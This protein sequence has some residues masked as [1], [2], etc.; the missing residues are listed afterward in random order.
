MSLKDF[1]ELC[2]LGLI[3]QEFNRAHQSWQ[4]HQMAC[5]AGGA[6]TRALGGKKSSAGASQ[7]RRRSSRQV[8]QGAKP[9]SLP[10][11]MRALADQRRGSDLRSASSAGSSLMAAAQD[12]G[13]DDE[14]MDTIYANWG[15]VEAHQDTGATTSATDIFLSTLKKVHRKFITA[16]DIAACGLEGIYMNMAPSCRALL[17][18]ARFP[19][20]AQCRRARH[21]QGA[22]SSAVAEVFPA[23]GGSPGDHRPPGRLPVGPRHAALQQQRPA[24]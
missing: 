11:L 24:C 18:G 2:R 15:V 14:V 8:Q 13:D 1:L 7:Q 6:G 22:G 3:S 19:G 9:W 23:G 20:M 12:D 16:E 5:T 10:S 21:Q 17:T 4:N